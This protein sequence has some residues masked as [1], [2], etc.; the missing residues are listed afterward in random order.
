MPKITIKTHI[1]MP[2]KRHRYFFRVFPS[3]GAGLRASGQKMDSSAFLCPVARVGHR[4]NIFFCAVGV[5]R[6]LGSLLSFLR[7]FVGKMVNLP[8]FHPWRVLGAFC[9]LFSLPVFQWSILPRES[10]LTHAHACICL[11]LKNLTTNHISNRQSI[12]KRYF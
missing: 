3:N 6:F 11:F 2:P 4:E 5:R 7:A 8:A 10:V 9:A 12:N 1:K